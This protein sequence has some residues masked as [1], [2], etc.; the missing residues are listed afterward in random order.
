MNIQIYYKQIKNIHLFASLDVAEYCNWQS[1]ESGLLHFEE[2]ISALDY[3]VLPLDDSFF[4][5]F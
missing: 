2:Q 1:Q 4:D 5:F 3:S